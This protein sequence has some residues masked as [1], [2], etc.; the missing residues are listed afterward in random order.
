MFKCTNYGCDSRVHYSLFNMHEWLW[1]HK[2]LV[3]CPGKHCNNMST[4]DEMLLH[5]GQCPYIEIYCDTCETA[6]DVSVGSHNC[7]LVLKKRL[8]NELKGIHYSGP[9][10]NHSSQQ[11]VLPQSPSIATIEDQ[12][13]NEIK[14]IV[15]S[16][17]FRDTCTVRNVLTRNKA[18]SI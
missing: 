18:C 11:V 8:Y 4:A 12:D 2:R 10:K 6:F 5:I 13:L 16:H 15:D 9:L 17:M 1:C 14:D 7:A 3:K